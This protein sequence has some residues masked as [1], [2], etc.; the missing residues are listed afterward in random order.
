MCVS[1]VLFVRLRFVLD[2]PGWG[3]DGRKSHIA[4]LFF[5]LS[6]FILLKH[7]F[8][9]DP[10]SYPWLTDTSPAILFPHPSTQPHN[11]TVSTPLK[12]PHLTNTPQHIPPHNTSTNHTSPLPHSTSHPTTH[13]ATTPHP[14]PTPHPTPPHINQPRLTTTPHHIPPL[15][16]STLHASPILHT[17]SHPTTQHINPLKLARCKVSACVRECLYDGFWRRRSIPI[18]RPGVV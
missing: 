3:R 15:H 5:S 13:L 18:C 11:K 16:T 4:N 8:I 6:G 1:A 12:R 2:M 9:P 17:T 14:Y 7:P 10:T